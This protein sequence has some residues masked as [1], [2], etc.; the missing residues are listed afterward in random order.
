MR[1][2][3]PGLLFTITAWPQS[4]P[5]FSATMRAITSVAPPAGYGTTMLTVLLG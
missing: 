4:L 5:S 2:P 1:V 3:A